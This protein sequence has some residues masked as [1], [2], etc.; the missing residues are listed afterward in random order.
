MKNLLIGVLF[1]FPFLAS[2]STLNAS[3]VSSIIG[4]L[5]AFGVSQSIMDSVYADL[6]TTPTVSPV[7]VSSVVPV[8][9]P[10]YIVPA[11]VAQPAAPQAPIVAKEPV[12]SAAPVIPAPTCTLSGTVG[13][14]TGLQ[15]GAY[16][17]W[18]SQN[19]T[20]GTITYTGIF[21]QK[22]SYN[23]DPIDSGNI[24]GFGIYMT[25][26]TGRVYTFEADVVG[27]GGAGV[28][29]TTVTTQ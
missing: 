21:A 7:V 25:P 6:V 5:K 1:A 17:T 28:C 12:A 14:N 29:T 2:A 24:A 19:A 16:L 13:Y 8:P 22:G 10:V 3:Q 26:S 20:A 9:Q 23:M 11:P 27:A 15:E 4:L 18:T